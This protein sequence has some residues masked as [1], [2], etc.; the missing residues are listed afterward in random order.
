MGQI[1]RWLGLQ[2]G[3]IVPG[4]RTSP[5]ELRTASYQADVATRTNNEM[6][7]DYLRDDIAQT[8]T[9]RPS[10]T[11]ATTPSSTRSTRSSSTRPA[12]R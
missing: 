5:A 9:T 8:K 1:H 2:V 3:V 12:R 7:F 11:A 10:D 4:Y 6:G